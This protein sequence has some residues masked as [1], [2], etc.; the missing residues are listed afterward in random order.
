MASNSGLPVAKQSFFPSKAH[1]LSWIALLCTWG[2]WLMNSFDYNLVYSTAPI[3]I[4]EFNVTPE[5]WGFLVGM[6]TL[7]RVFVDLPLNIW[8]DRVGS[9]WR[10]KLLWAP[11]VVFYAVL[12]F[13]TGFKKL[14]GHILAYFGLRTGVTIGGTACE[15]IGVAASSEWWAEE[16][17]GFA[18][19]AHHT[20]F[21]LGGLMAGLVTSAFIAMFGAHNWRWVFFVSLLSIPL[22]YWYWRLATPENL[23]TVYRHIDERGLTRPH[24]QEVSVASSWSGWT[25]VFKRYEIVSAAI[26]VLLFMGVYILF[27]TTF[28]AYLSFVGGY[29]YEA[30][31]A[32]SFV[33]AI[34]G[35]TFQVLLPWL[36]DYV[37]R[38]WILVAAGFY[39]GFIMLL[40]PY[41]TTRFWVIAVQVLYGVVLNAVYPIAFSTAADAA[42]KGRVATAVSVTTTFLWIGAA[43]AGF[44]AGQLIGL[45]GGWESRTGYLYVFYLMSG[46][47]FLA[48]ILHLFARETA[49]IKV[50]RGQAKTTAV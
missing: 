23:E 12:S 3:A 14:S 36:S 4:K 7:V 43:V 21:P 15:A 38:K 29:S 22:V 39:A 42:P 28:P 27:I 49:A 5:Y 24:G 17:R 40:L 25:E 26:Y 2:I 48:G 44:V 20:G 13:L 18:V 9:G 33:W 11:I 46:A 6:W 16:N 45:G 47:S 35:A 32:L 50:R 8:C 31:A 1:R 41:A 30:V 37:G 19:G 34:T 10:R